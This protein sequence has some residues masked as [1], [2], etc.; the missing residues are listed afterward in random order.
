[1]SA[2]DVDQT[3][4][5]KDQSASTSDQLDADKDQR[6]SD[7]DQATAD[8]DHKSGHDLTAADQSD[9][10]ASRE[11]RDSGSY[12]RLKTRLNRSTTAQTRDATADQRDQVAE[13]RDEVGV[14]RDTRAT[15]L[16]RIASAPEASLTRQLEELAAKAAADRARA[17]ADRARAAR[18]RAEAAV[19]RARLEA[20]LRSAHL[21]ELTGAYRREMGRLALSNEITRARRSDGRFVLAFVDVD[22]LKEVNDRDGHAAGDRVL[23][24][25]IHTIRARLRSFDPIIRYGGDEFVCG[26]SGTDLAEAERRFDAISQTLEADASVGISVG[27]AALTVGDTAEELTERADAAMLEVKALHHSRA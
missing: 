18:D 22:R 4:S 26:L 21:D 23:Q 14:A 25:V 17:A 3:L 12:D 7:R 6:A 16:A 15:D 5:D 20:E 10:D 13:T 24:K 8:R 19:E 2:S 1:Q 27:F 9:Y 11:E